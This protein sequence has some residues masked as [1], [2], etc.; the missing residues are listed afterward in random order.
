[1]IAQLIFQWAE[2]TPERTAVIYNGKAYS[3]RSFARAIALARGYFAS[4]GYLGPGYAV[5][6]VSIA[7]NF[8]ILSLALRSLGLTTVCVKSPAILRQLAG[9][10]LTNVR[11]VI[12]TTGEIWGGSGRAMHRT[13]PKS[14]V[15]VASW[16]NCPAARTARSAA[17]VGRAYLADLGH[18]R[19]PQ[20]GADESRDRRRH[21]SAPCGTL[22]H[23]PAYLAQCVQPW[24]LDRRRLQV[25]GLPL[26]CG[27][28]H[29]HRARGRTIPGA[30][31]PGIT[32]AVLF[33]ELLAAILAAPAGAFP[34]ND[35]MQLAVGSG[36]MT[37]TQ[38]DQAKARIT[39]H[40]FHYFVSTE[41][42]LIAFTS[43]DTPEDQRWH[44]LVP[45]RMV[46]IVDASDRP[47]PIGEVGQ[48][49]VSTA[50]GPTGYLNDETATRAFFRD[51]FFYPG[52]L[53]VMRSDGRI[54]LQGRITDI[55]NVQGNKI[56]PAPIEERLGELF[57]LNGVCLFS[58]QNDSGEEEFHV[59]L[60][61]PKP[62]DSERLI[63]A[64]KQELGGFHP[65]HVYYVATLPRNDMGKVLR[66][67][68]RAQVISKMDRN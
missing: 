28:R 45:G 66:Q 16:R 31:R 43:L 7:M 54:A 35:T 5:L 15:S 4:R 17:P 11:C 48:V 47:V 51:G 50:G 32:H 19:H 61:T 33:P 42:G 22:R 23:R 41:A 2:Q 59:V 12:T 25:G 55:I 57:G 37:R 49:R 29:S 52:D 68:V 9:R 13:R 1:M 8:W 65:A 62:I 18:D 58:M 36:A 44:R 63:A 10:G 30:V 27:R 34:R 60:E 56:S 67:E 39:S 53:A 38:V 3:Y 20:N 46:E 6:A 26:D 14:A 40:L 64:L 24:D 21:P